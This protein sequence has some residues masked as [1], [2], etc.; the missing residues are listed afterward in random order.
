MESTNINKFKRG[1]VRESNYRLLSEPV[2]L[3]VKTVHVPDIGELRWEDDGGPSIEYISEET[4]EAINRSRIKIRGPRKQTAAR[5]L[6]PKESIRIVPVN[7]PR[8]PKELEDRA[9]GLNV[10]IAKL[11]TQVRNFKEEARR[12][13]QAENARRTA[14]ENLERLFNVQRRLSVVK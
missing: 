14:L 8:T 12:K 5:A 3:K 9:L 11:E 10:Q 2:Q 13:A 1:D 7:P 4:V 6:K